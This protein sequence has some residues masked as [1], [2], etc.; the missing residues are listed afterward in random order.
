MTP[1]QYQR[2]GELYHEALERSP[3]ERAAYLKEACAGDEE[4]RRRVEALIL[5]HNRAGEFLAAPG[6]SLLSSLP[7]NRKPMI[8]AGVKFGQYEVVS[9]IGIGG[10]GEVY[11]AYDTR[12]GR[13]IALKL[14][15]T[16][17]TQDAD[18]VRRF[19]QEAR[20]ASSLNH[21]NIITIYD[22]GE[23]YLG[24]GATH[25]IA[26][27]YID[28]QTL[29]QRLN[30]APINLP[31]ALQIIVQTS[32]ALAAAHK[33]GIVHR[34]VKPENIMIRRDGYV[35]VLDFGLAKL[36]ESGGA[37]ER[38]S[39]GAAEREMKDEDIDP[40]KQRVSPSHA[41]PLSR[42]SF[43]P[44]SRSQQ[45]TTPG[46]VLGTFAYMSP[47][48]AQG[49]QVDTRSDIFSLGIVLYEMIA[50]RVPFDGL[51]PAEVMAAVLN[52]RTPSLAP[53]AKGIPA[54]LERIVTKALAKDREERYQMMKDLLADLKNLK[55]ELEVEARLK[56]PDSTA[57]R[58]LF[59]P[60][61]GAVPLDSGFY[62]IRSTDEKFR[63]AISRQDSIVL[64]KGARQVGKTS[65]LARGLQQARE[66][67]AHVVLTDFQSISAEYLDSIGRFW[68]TLANAFADQLDLDVAPDEV[69]KPSRSPSV[70]FEQYLR[71]EVLLKFSAPV[72][73][74]LDEVDRLFTCNF[75]SEVF[76]LFRSW[77]NKRALDP[78]GPWQKLTLA[79]AYATEAHLFITDLNQSPFNV[80]TRLQLND[81]TLE[82]VAKLNER[83]GSPL[84]DDDEIAR[85][86]RLLSGHPYLVRRGLHEMVTS[87]VDL[88]DLEAG[89]VADEGP[90]G[91]HL[92]RLLISLGKDPELCDV[93]RG[94][95]QGKPCPTPESFYR[96][97]S[98]GLASGESTQDI[99]PRCLLYETYL[100]RHLL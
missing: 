46:I 51:S 41:P 58:D 36:T 18:R 22:I 17:Y 99:K 12:L 44:L 78:Q 85:Y 65:L 71:R 96:L 54:E 98:A 93:V 94:I 86:Y 23:A 6:L 2:I 28:G 13:H 43:P 38:E 15:P 100:A 19:K 52:R 30:E 92:H 84:K 73:W 90:F 8:A 7:P 29:R 25:F 31:E 70:N 75:G 83:Y 49:Q 57:L 48:Q 67:G 50:G 5:A 95:L 14:L 55:F 4:L 66:S 61:G 89:A 32:D 47:E 42:S 21:P 10:M 26:T 68:L 74:G 24:E 62:I 82:E 77:H 59:E 80:G 39:G 97:R 88:T 11:Q 33:A 1:E 27:E 16:Q 72:V 60:V 37:A 9:L 35:K 40:R 20:A 91:D 63:Q 76:G 64:V 87:N 34:D 53:Y 79:I 69:W 3:D 45:S 56:N 81:F